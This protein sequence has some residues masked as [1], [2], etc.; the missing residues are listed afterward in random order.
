[1]YFYKTK[2]ILISI[3]GIL[4][5]F[6]SNSYSAEYTVPLSANSVY[7]EDLDLDGYKDIV[8]G[9]N[10]ESLTEWG[11]VSILENLSEGQYLLTD[12]LK[13]TNGFGFHEVNGNYID[14][15][16]YIDI[17]G[18][19]ISDD[20]EP[21]NNRF[22]GI[23]YNYGNQGFNNIVYYPLNTRIYM[24][25][26]TSGDI[27]NDNDID[28]LVTSGNDQ[29]FGILY[30]D[31]TGQFSLPEY[32][33]L[34][35]YPGDIVCGDLNGDDRE[36]I[37]ISGGKNLDAWL[38]LETGLQYY[39][40]ASDTDYVWAKEITD[41]DQDGDNDIIGIIWYMPGAKTKI[42]VYSNDGSGNYQLS[43]I[44]WIDEAMAEIFVS[45]LNNDDYPDIIY[46]VSYSYPNS[47]YETIHTYILF[48]NC[49][50]TFQDQVNYLTYLGSSEYVRSYKPFAADLDNNGWKDIITVNY[51]CNESSIHIFFNDGTG[52]FVEESPVGINEDE[53]VIRNI[54]LYQNYPNPFNN[55]TDIEYQIPDICEVELCV[56]NSKGEFV[57]YLVND[58]QNKGNYYIT[59]NGN[60]LNSGI[61]YYRLDI[62][63]KV[64]AVNKMLYLK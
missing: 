46:N 47:D 7:A 18:L 4:L 40:I 61:Y 45:D 51:S 42:A 55:Q 49:D 29:F 26:I 6:F 33:S 16:N 39:N 15:D 30:N 20:P 10:Y 62:D 3:I 56:Y 59:F 14:N 58:K 23:I 54:K 22:V 57:K 52:N 50:G 2:I 32:H 11:G 43:F 24:Y 41:I 63:G 21:I 35:Y 36:D 64:R 1:M 9:H 60:N 27:D 17:F 19:F 31:G 34:D 53:A 5:L 44:K 28:I 37:L 13:F 38:N 25:D 8:V 48:N 12:S